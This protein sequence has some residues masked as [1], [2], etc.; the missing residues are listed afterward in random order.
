MLMFSISRLFIQVQWASWGMLSELEQSTTFWL[1]AVSPELLTVVA[2]FA[3]AV[4]QAVV[5]VLAADF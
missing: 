4:A 3:V 1:V 5:L 2:I